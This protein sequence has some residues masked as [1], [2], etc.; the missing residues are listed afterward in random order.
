VTGTFEHP[1]PHVLREYALIADG[2]RG[3][4]CGP[5]G[6][7]C[8]MCAP[9]WHDDAVFATLIGGSGG[10]TVTPAA[11]HVWG[12]S[13]EQ[14]SLIWRNRWVTDHTVVEC[15]DAL[16]VPAD[17]HR[18]IVL[19]RIIVVGDAAA[20]L[21]V[22]LDVRADFG[23]SSMIELSRDE[24]G[25]WVG[26]S[27]RLAFRWSGAESARV[28]GQG[29]LVVDLRIPAGGSHDLVL[30]I[31]DGPLA[32][33]PTADGLWESTRRSW[34]EAVPEF[35][36]AAAPVDARQ[37]YAVM[38]GLT[39]GS[40][41]MVAAATMSLPERAEAGRNYDYRYVWLRDQCYAGLAVAAHGPDRLLTDAV[42]FVAGALLSDGVQVRPAYTCDGAAVPDERH[43]RLAGY[44]GGAD[45]RGNHA[46]RQFQLDTPGE[47]LQ[48]FT[49]A[50]RLGMIDRDLVKAVQTAVAVIESRWREPD[51]GLW[52][53]END[54]WTHSRL[55]CVAG[56]REAATIPAFGDGDRLTGL[57]ETIFAET[58]RRCLN[59]AGFWQRSPS[60]H[61]VDASLLLPPVRGGIAADDP[62]TVATL[63]A[64]RQRLV[65]DGYVYRYEQDGHRLGELEGAFLLCGFIAALAEAQQGEV[66]RAFRF[67]ERNRSA[68]GS[69]GLLAE[70]F[71]VTQRQLRGNL[72][73][74]FVHALALQSSLALGRLSS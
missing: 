25:A 12:G 31:S 23:L 58:S 40:G 52:E 47:A 55:A 73:Q 5:H 46:N 66:V 3:A 60:R 4:L 54:W 14:G 24:H 51:A 74:A 35:A 61:G 41:G 13:Y 42:T 7:L 53:L 71:D 67:F 21:R 38:R 15:H 22:A 2:R 6:D 72:P 10:Y 16:A 8:W 57:A 30:E 9:Q 49:A 43:L 34:Q 45:I 17:P 37:A 56:L 11:R 59:P 32:E 36:T 48:L 65:V 27:G 28:D 68:C 19:R 62:R 33:L 63:R 39:A 20:E 50:G 64:V 44:P 29:Q 26:R 70:E 1:A 69:P 18:A